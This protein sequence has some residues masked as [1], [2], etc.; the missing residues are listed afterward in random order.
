MKRL[1][2]V[3]VL[4]MAVACAIKEPPK[5]FISQL[6]W[7]KWDPEHKHCPKSIYDAEYIPNYWRYEWDGHG[8]LEIAVKTFIWE[9]S[10]AMEY[11]H[12]KSVDG[13]DGYIFPKKFVAADGKTL[14]GP[15]IAVNAEFFDLTSRCNLRVNFCDSLEKLDMVFKGINVCSSLS[16]RG[17]PK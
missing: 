9:F 3:L 14:R 8:H 13:I 6:N 11:K 2:I 1:L 5:P 16:Y 12:Y 10:G 17:I 15:F 4:V 7:D